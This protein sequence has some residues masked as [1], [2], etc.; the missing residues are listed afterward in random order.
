MY[1]VSELGIARS[2][3]VLYST[4]DLFDRLPTNCPEAALRLPIDWLLAHI[5]AIDGPMHYSYVLWLNTLLFLT[6]TVGPRLAFPSP[7]YHSRS[8]TSS[9]SLIQVQHGEI[10]QCYPS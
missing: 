3:N 2:A 7:P 10:A 6:S 1:D 8:T 4:Y 9:N 5:S